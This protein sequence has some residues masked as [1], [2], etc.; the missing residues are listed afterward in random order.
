MHK[1]KALFCVKRQ[2]RRKTDF[3]KR[4]SR[5]ECERKTEEDQRMANQ[6]DTED[7]DNC[8]F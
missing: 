2:K 6:R 1:S 3:L 4:R 8:K 7:T 5:A